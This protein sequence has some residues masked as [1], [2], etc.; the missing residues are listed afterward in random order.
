MLLEA[1]TEKCNILSR[2][3]ENTPIVTPILSPRSGE[4]PPLVSPRSACRS[5]ASPP[6]LNPLLNAPS[7]VK[8]GGGTPHLSPQSEAKVEDSAPASTSGT[9]VGAGEGVQQQIPKPRTGA[10]NPSSVTDSL[11]GLAFAERSTL[12]GEEPTQPM[13]PSAATAMLKLELK[14]RD[15]RILELE[16]LLY[17]AML[18]DSGVAHRFVS[19]ARSPAAGC[20]SPPALWR[21]TLPG[22]EGQTPASEARS[23][24]SVSP[25]PSAIQT[26]PGFNFPDDS[27]GFRGTPPCQDDAP[28]AAIPHAAK[29]APDGQE[30][31]QDAMQ[32][33][34]ASAGKQDSPPGGAGPCQEEAATNT[35]VAMKDEDAGLVDAMARVELALDLPFNSIAGREEEFSKELCEDVAGAIGGDATKLHVLDLQSGSIIATLGLE[36]G[37]C[38]ADV[39]ADDVAC[40]IAQQAQDPA[41]ALRAQDRR[42]SSTATGARVVARLDASVE[43]PSSSWRASTQIIDTRA[44]NDSAPA[45]EQPAAAE[46]GSAEAPERETATSSVSSAAASASV[47]HEPQHDAVAPAAQQRISLLSRIFGPTRRKT[48]QTSATDPLVAGLPGQS[49]DGEGGVQA[50]G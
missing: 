14:E 9:R 18:Y 25:L 26:P 21:L 16:A 42:I 24:V 5:G 45:P 39:A 17:E 50:V 29:Q 2:S 8:V 32:E 34:G 12:E 10:R 48:A 35:H 40:L 44:A 49:D 27:Y 3:L 13:L 46:A 37:V 1:T 36:E 7:A 47:Q 19:Q 28:A 31:E 41:S 33:V 15:Q 20:A 11:E 30:T 23:F 43:R 6:A 38:G 22:R 4:V